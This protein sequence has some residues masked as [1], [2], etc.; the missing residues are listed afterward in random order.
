MDP[1]V[2]ISREVPLT[3]GETY[4]SDEGL[5]FRSP[6]TNETCLMLGLS[7]I[8]GTLNN[9][10]VTESERIYTVAPAGVAIARLQAC[11]IPVGICTARAQGEAEMYARAVGARGVIISENG[12]CS[13]YP[14]GERVTIGDMREIRECVSAIESRLGRSLV[15]SLD[16]EALEA[17]WLEQERSREEGRGIGVPPYKNDLGHST[18]EEV[19]M[20]AAR[21]A[22]AY[23]SGLAPEERVVA[24][25]IAEAYGFRPFGDLLHLI[26][27]RAD[28]GIALDALCER[29]LAQDLV[30]FDEKGARRKANVDRVTPIVF[31]NG[32]NDLPLF[33]S[34]I[35]RGGYG[36][37]VADPVRDTGFHFSFHERPP[38]PKTLIMQ[39]TPYGYG[40][41]AA[42]PQIF[43]LIRDE[44]GIVL[45]LPL[46]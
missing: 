32:E 14:G 8:D 34:A 28:K 18:V 29:F 45:R 35:E 5:V 24:V 6:K 16:I 12:A 13:T 25:A 11:G 20:S 31:G 17:R 10:H 1:R 46:I 19:R 4:R 23:I 38:P 43:S 40:M 37:L 36:V 9:E 27:R 21:I 22:S 26:N 42:I 15:T 44:Y 30:V 7:D 33:A 2:Q 41:K 39:G 3:P